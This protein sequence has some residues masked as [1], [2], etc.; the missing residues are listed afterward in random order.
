MK[1][2]IVAS[3]PKKLDRK[4]MIGSDS[5]LMKLNRSV[6][7]KWNVGDILIWLPLETGR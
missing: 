1:N 3:F 5:N 7:E 4:N 2:V 6:N